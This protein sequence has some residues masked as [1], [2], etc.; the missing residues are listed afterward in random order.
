MSTPQSSHEKTKDILSPR[1]SRRSPNLQQK[2][3]FLHPKLEIYN[4]SSVSMG[5]LKDPN[6]SFLNNLRSDEINSNTSKPDIEPHGHGSVF[7]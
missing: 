4:E 5:T 2:H 1:S 6:E 7:T 3:E